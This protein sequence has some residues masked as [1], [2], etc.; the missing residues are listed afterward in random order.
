VSPRRSLGTLLLLV[1]VAGA[2][3]CGAG[4][5][6]ETDKE[7]ATPYLAKG[8]AGPVAVRA[9]RVVVA[10]DTVPA[11]ASPTA[12]ASTSATAVPLA[13]AT[14]SASSGAGNGPQAYLVATVVNRAG[15]P[16]QLTNATVSGGSVQPI[17]ADSSSLSLP[18]NQV[19]RF[20]DPEVGSADVALGIGGLSTG[21]VPGKSVRVTLTFQNA[22]TVSIVVPITTS[23]D[24]GTTASAAP[25][26]TGG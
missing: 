17:A 24:I 8:D 12:S 3:G 15:T 23:D 20:G 4:R 5:D 19:V 18:P 2:A 10:G 1:T 16:D 6:T 14:P 9:V 21:L 22:G 25:V 26:V 13:S 11:A 7:R